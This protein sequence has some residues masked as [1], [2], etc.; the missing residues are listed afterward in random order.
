MEAEGVI[1]AI[2]V[3]V[4]KAIRISRATLTPEIR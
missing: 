1:M 2:T 3:R 4:L